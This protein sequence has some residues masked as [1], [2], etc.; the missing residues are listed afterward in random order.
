MA[1][2]IWIGRYILAI[3]IALVL[4]TAIGEMK[5]FQ[6]TTVGTAKLTA[7]GLVKFMGYAGALGMLWLLGL[8]AAHQM[9]TRGGK[10]TFFGLVL[11]PLVTLIAV[12]SLYGVVLL[13]AKPFF[14]PALQTI[15][16]WVFVVAITASA[17]WLAV[18]LFQHAE[19]LAELFGTRFTASSG[20]P[21]SKCRDCGIAL[22]PRAKFC[23]A[24]GV[25][26]A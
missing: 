10:A 1:Q 20:Q 18:A 11:V 13:L 5:L 26:T 21:A 17:V 6:Q 15:Y 7:A 2:W 16:N 14:G 12:S 19:T 3:V 25:P 9:R 22:A 4:G 8:K 23:Y 24:C